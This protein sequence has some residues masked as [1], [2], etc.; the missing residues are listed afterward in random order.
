M[1][2]HEQSN[3]ADYTGNPAHFSEYVIAVVDRHEEA[4]RAA[5]ALQAAGF[6]QDD[7]VLSPEAGQ[8]TILLQASEGMEESL[9]EPPTTGEELFTEEGI[10]QELYATERAQGHV[11]VRIHTAKDEQ[12]ET[13]RAVLAAHHAHAIR[14]VGTWTRETLSDKPGA[15][16]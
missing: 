12:V 1:S 5:A 16:G 9:A 10:D 7:I 6:S 2:S 13:A 15:A 14:H 4:R 11:I 8:S 3:P